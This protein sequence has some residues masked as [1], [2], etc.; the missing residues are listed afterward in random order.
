MLAFISD[1]FFIPSVLVLANILK[2]PPTIAGVV[3]LGIAGGIPDILTTYSQVKIGSYAQAIGFMIGSC[4]LVGVFMVAVV[5]MIKETSVKRIP[6]M[7]DVSFFILTICAVFLILHDAYVHIWEP[8]GLLVLYLFY[9]IAVVVERAVHVRR[10]RHCM[11]A[12]ILI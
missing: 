12:K 10:K 6:F 5:T 2:M 8:I 9:V 4:M 3:L 1:R 11:L 7:I